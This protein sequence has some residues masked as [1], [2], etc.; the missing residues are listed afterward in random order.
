M[1]E[2]NEAEEMEELIEQDITDIEID[3]DK[4]DHLEKGAQIGKTREEE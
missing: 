1:N 3:P 4:M 2:K